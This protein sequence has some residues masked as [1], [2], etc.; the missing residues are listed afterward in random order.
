MKSPTKKIKVG[1][2]EVYCRN[3]KTKKKGWIDL[4][5]IVERLLEVMCDDE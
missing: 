4:S 5:E 1:N 2:V 3:K